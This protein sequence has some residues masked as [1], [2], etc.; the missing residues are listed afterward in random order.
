MKIN[1]S[2]LK[3]MIA[4]IEL[5]SNE[6]LGILMSKNEYGHYVFEFYE[7]V[8]VFFDEEQMKMLQE[9]LWG[10]DGTV[11]FFERRFESSHAKGSKRELLNLLNAAYLLSI[12]HEKINSMVKDLN[13]LY[14][15][16]IF[17]PSILDIDRVTKQFLLKNLSLDEFLQL[18]Y[19]EK[20]RK[21]IL[22]LATEYMKSADTKEYHR[23]A[24]KEFKNNFKPFNWG[25]YMRN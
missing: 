17:N 2:H 21:E 20:S 8:Y 6:E 24:L 25:F 7:E 4:K 10:I 23:D 3:K 1:V 15:K 5:I 19:V 9:T 18:L 13:F 11:T 16:V 14:C 12:C 22:T